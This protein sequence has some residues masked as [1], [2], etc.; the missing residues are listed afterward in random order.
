MG[1]KFIEVIEADDSEDHPSPSLSVTSC[2]ISNL[3][4]ICQENSG[5]NE[6]VWLTP[7][8]LHDFKIM[9]DRAMEN[10]SKEQIEQAFLS[11]MM[12][13]ANELQEHYTAGSNNWH[14]WKAVSMF[15]S[16]FKKGAR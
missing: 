15:L 4:S 7:S 10:P 11:R 12:N 16:I 2:S 1:V 3:F 9:L 13:E 6:C 5:A 14:K 8:Q